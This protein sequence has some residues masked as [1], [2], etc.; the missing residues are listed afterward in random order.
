MTTAE[1]VIGASAKT[2]SLAFERVIGASALS[3]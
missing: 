1:G 2:T 3:S